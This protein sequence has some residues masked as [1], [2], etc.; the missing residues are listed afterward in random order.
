MSLASRRQKAL[1]LIT[2]RSLSL[3]HLQLGQAASVDCSHRRVIFAGIVA[4]SRY[5]DAILFFDWG[6]R[7]TSPLVAVVADN[8]LYLL[9]GQF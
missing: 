4:E 5:S 7:H 9:Y 3:S 2:V 1:S 6:D 8:G